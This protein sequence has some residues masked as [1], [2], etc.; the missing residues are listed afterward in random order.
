MKKK[1]YSVFD[2]DNPHYLYAGLNLN[3]KK[4]CIKVI[5][6]M[7]IDSNELPENWN[8]MSQDDK[9]EFIICACNYE[10]KKHKNKKEL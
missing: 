2:N 4:E 7:L 6:T 1:Y 9:E 10:I 3:S 8:E 5:E